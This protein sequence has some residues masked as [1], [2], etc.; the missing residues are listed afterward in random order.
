M[1]QWSNGYDSTLSHRKNL[2]SSTLT[3]PRG[4][5]LAYTV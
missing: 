4:V 3:P 1:P 5:T 2:G